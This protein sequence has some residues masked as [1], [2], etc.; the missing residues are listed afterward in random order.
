MREWH[1]A[2][3][4]ARPVVTAPYGPEEGRFVPLVLPATCPWSDYQ[5]DPCSIA[6]HHW[7]ERKHGPAFRVLVLECEV[8]D[9]AFTLYPLGHVP[10]GRAAVAPVNTEG[11]VLRTKP[12]KPANDNANRQH[13]AVLAA[14]DRVDWRATVFG[15]A[16]DAAD[17]GKAPWPRELCYEQ[18]P[19]PTWDTQRA[20]L[21]HGARILGIAPVP[22][23][24][25]GEQ[26]ANA[27]SIPRLAMRDAE[28]AWKRADVYYRERGRVLTSVLARLPT[29]RRA[30]DCI[31][32][33]G[34]LAGAWGAVT[35]WQKG[36]RGQAQA[37]PRRF[38][39]GGTGFG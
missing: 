14:L 29:A 2:A 17:E 39:S 13:D 21:A 19:G 28:R 38:P 6:R 25:G 20:R 35:R 12:S 1:S 24:R 37:R 7:R 18:R 8:H 33:A 16:L 11:E 5:S 26:I 4:R 34:A 9:H 32:A 15:A 36:A 23:P 10:Y 30:L 31:L 22:S 27:L 3:A